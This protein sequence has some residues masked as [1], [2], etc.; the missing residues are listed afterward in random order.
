MSRRRALLLVAIILGSPAWPAE[1]ALKRSLLVAP[2]ETGALSRE[3]AWIGDGIAEAL[4]L[5]FVQHP[6]FVGIDRARLR[7][8]AD[9]QG[10]TE[11]SVLQAARALHADVA[12]FGDVTGSISGSTVQPTDETKLRAY[13]DECG[14]RYE[15]NPGEKTASSTAT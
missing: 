15:R 4:A 3:D 8:V 9:P 14:K 12:V 2:F 13:A 5:A 11:A 7:T 10:W 1:A 6:A